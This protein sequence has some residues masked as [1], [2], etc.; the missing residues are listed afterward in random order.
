MSHYCEETPSLPLWIIAILH[1]TIAKGRYKRKIRKPK[2][3]IEQENLIAQAF[4]VAE[5]E[6][7]DLK[8]SS[9]IEAASCKDAA[10]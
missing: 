4:V 6:I 8:P 3:L 2:F 7:K 1:Y 5:E 10:Q 9:Y